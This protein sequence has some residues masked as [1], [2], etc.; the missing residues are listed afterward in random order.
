M[1][2][3]PPAAVPAGNREGSIQRLKVRGGVLAQGADE[4]VGQEVPLVHIA[5]HGTYPA[6]FGGGGS[7]LGLGLDVGL[8]IGVGDAGVAG[9]QVAVLHVGQEQGVG[10]QVQGGDHLA[11]QPGAG[12]PGYIENAVVPPDGVRLE[13]VKLVH[14]PAGLE[15]EA[16]EGG[17][18][19][20]LRQ[21]GQGE[22]A[23]LQHHVVGVVGLV[24]RDDNAVGL[25]GH[26][27]GGVDDAAVVLFSLAGGQNKQTVAQGKHGL[28]IFHSAPPQVPGLCG[29]I[30][31]APSVYHSAGEKSRQIRIILVCF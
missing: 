12:P 7:G 10:A 23:G 17:E 26:L 24:H 27:H 21:D 16:L 8:I 22:A 28:G 20:L 1:K 6:L 2:N 30:L 4:V 31:S 3:F 9:E 13:A 18:L 14:I 29:Q 11:A 5:A 15:A 19:R 25:A